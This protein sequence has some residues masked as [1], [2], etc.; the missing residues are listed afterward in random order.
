MFGGAAGVELEAISG[1][2]RARVAGERE[3]ATEI[4]S[5]AKD[6]LPASADVTGQGT[7]CLGA[8]PGPG[9]FM[10]GGAGLQ[11]CMKPPP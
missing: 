7:T 10:R 3:P 1:R 6:L 9:L 11:A 5:A 8:F 2:E 4:L